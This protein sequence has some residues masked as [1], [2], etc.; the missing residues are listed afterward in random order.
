M[1]EHALR[2][3]ELARYLARFGFDVLAPD[4]PG[5]GLSRTDGGCRKIHPLPELLSFLRE[6]KSAWDREG[7][8]ASKNP[9]NQPWYLLGHSMG[10]LLALLWIIE[11]KV[12]GE[13]GEFARRAFVSA[14]PLKV[15]LAVPIWK[16]MAAQG[17]A[18][19]GGLLP[20]ASGISPDDLSFDA[21]NVAAYRS[22]PFV[23]GQTTA[24]QFLSIN[25]AAE[26]VSA[27]VGDVE[28]PVF[29][30]VG[31]EDPIVDPAAVRDFYSRI[32]THKRFLEMPNAK[33]EILNEIDREDLYAQ[34]AGWFL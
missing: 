4:M 33:H 28:I 31:Q 27:Q 13:S 25:Q 10:A 19:T 22:D 21:A 1:G 9:E 2:Y 6:S 8:L 32:R 3:A 11:G 5:Y 26:K 20:L 7:P 14:P 18:P 34:V 24:A 30:A 29:L 23:H 15:R 17:L 16:R 12:S